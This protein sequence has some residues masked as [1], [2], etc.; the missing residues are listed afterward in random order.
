MKKAINAENAPTAVGPYVHAVEKDDMVFTSGQLGLH[1]TTGEMEDGVEAQAHQSLKNL[2]AVLEAAG[3]DFDHVIKTTVFLA[4]MEDFA[5]VNKIY[6]TYFKG[7]VPARSCVEVARL[8]KD[9]LVE[10]E[11]IAVKRT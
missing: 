3:S 8:P 4:N 1:P 9:G 6:A 11:A 7:E 10:I 2:G 5:V